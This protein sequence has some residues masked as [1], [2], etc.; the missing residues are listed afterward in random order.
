MG[1]GNGVEIINVHGVLLVMPALL[2]IATVN[3]MRGS[4]RIFQNR[5]KRGDMSSSYIE[6]R[7]E[8]FPVLRRVWSMATEKEVT[9]P[10]I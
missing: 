4:Q 7:S 2:L 1:I 10:P 5:T 9:L 8:K 6:S 3:L